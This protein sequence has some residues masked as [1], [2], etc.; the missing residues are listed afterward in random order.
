MSG[1]LLILMLLLSPTLIILW[2]TINRVGFIWS[3]LFIPLGAMTGFFLWGVGGAY[4]Y[5]LLI[6]LEDRQTGSPE[7]GAIGAA[8]GRA[9]VEIILMILFG[10]IGSGFSAW[11]VAS[12]WVS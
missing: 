3:L 10:W 9:I 8:T 7:A 6:W 4:F 2:T 12:H 5:T 11:W 1:Y